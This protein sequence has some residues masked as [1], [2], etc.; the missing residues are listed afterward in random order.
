MAIKFD[1][2][3]AFS[4]SPF[5]GNG[6]AVLHDAAH[7]DAQTC[8]NVVRETSLVECTFT[9]PSDV[10]DIRVRYFLASREIPFAGHPTLATV[11]AMRARGLIGDGTVTLET[12]AGLIPVEVDGDKIT[13]RQIAPV[14]GPFVSKEVLADAVG[15]E[16]GDIVA[17]PQVVSTGLPFCIGVVSGREA[18]ERAALD[19][20][21]MT[22]Y[23]A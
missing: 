20:D 4:A 8:M 19:V 21:G 10:A 13:M 17:A 7:L 9:G 16:A 11:A 22:K 2:V 1:W 23:R 15:L 12:Q 18:L 6:C 14:F 5:G 3:D